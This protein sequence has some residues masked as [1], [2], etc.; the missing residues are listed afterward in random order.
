MLTSSLSMTAYSASFFSAAY[1]I[2]RWFEMQR[3]S[4]FFFQ[5]IYITKQ[6]YFNF[7]CKCIVGNKTVLKHIK[8]HFSPVVDSSFKKLLLFFILSSNLL[9]TLLKSVHSKRLKIAHFELI[10]LI[11]ERKRTFS[12]L[13]LPSLY[14]HKIWYLKW[15]VR[16]A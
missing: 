13:K 15:K 1:L 2:K 16:V 3:R 5:N 6:F 8:S 14:G 10:S 7:V 4:F 12:Q 11:S 9:P